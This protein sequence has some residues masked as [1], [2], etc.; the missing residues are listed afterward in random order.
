M[1]WLWLLRFVAGLEIL[2]SNQRDLNY[3][4]AFVDAIMTSR[5]TLNTQIKGQIGYTED[6]TSKMNE[7]KNIYKEYMWIIK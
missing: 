2:P 3:Q 1:I 6:T 5:T 7:A 4:K